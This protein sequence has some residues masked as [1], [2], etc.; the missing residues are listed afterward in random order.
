MTSEKTTPPTP[1]EINA[2]GSQ[3]FKFSRF[4]RT[5]LVIIGLLLAAVLLTILFGDR[6]GV[7]LV[8]AA[9]LGTARSTSTVIIQFSETMQRD[10]VA[11]R[12]RL[13]ETQPGADPAAFQE[14]DALSEI[15][16]T[17]TWNG[18]TV[19]FRPTQ[20]LRPGAAYQVI[21]GK[22]AASESGRE[23][24]SEYRFAF[25]VRRPRV[26]YLA[27]ATGT[28]FNIWIAD[29]ADPASARQLTDSPSGILDLGVSP[30]GTKIAFSERNTETNTSDIKMIDIET[31][32][33][34]QLTNC[35]DADCKSPTWRPDGQIIAY[36]RVDYNS[37]MVGV[38]VSPTR[39]WLIDLSTTPAT[40][41]PL[42]D[43]SQKLGFGVQWSR[44]GDRLTVFDYNSQGILY[45]QF[46]ANTTA[47]VPSRYGSTGALSP[48]GNRIVFPEIII[49][50]NQ[51]RS[52]LQL[53]DME[54]EEITPL[55][56]PQGPN[57]DDTAA[58]SP[59][60][61]HLAIG[62]RY[63]D[64]RYTRG[65]QLYLLNVND[66][67]VLPLLLDPAYQM[68]IFIWDPTGEQML[69]QRFPDPTVLNDPENPGRPEIWTMNVETKALT[70]VAIDAFYPR[71]VP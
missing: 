22:G 43:D 26:A 69:I 23:L 30:D 66:G 17:V 64:D 52:Y 36:E 5:V 24:L 3:H 34:Q 33:I 21:L 46:S 37:D 70:Q 57:D 55:T 42:F 28:P 25:T 2:F 41:R 50:E 53:V 60:G 48:D 11:E 68:G 54:K 19:S 58:W 59:D 61:V 51:A 62:R 67:S 18:N 4:D 56:S 27:P 20:A 31:G 49:E 16:G 14:S 10:T 8:R 9:P 45:H 29:P 6:V 38:G 32:A 12:L 40:T 35:V 65:K 13:I 39:I 71:W 44:D 15:E 1:A 63:L 47:I 7:T